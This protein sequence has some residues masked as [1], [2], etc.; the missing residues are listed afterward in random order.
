MG[1]AQRQAEKRRLVTMVHVLLL[2]LQAPTFWTFHLPP[3]C[4]FTG[5]VMPSGFTHCFPWPG[6]HLSLSCP[7]LGVAG[8]PSNLLPTFSLKLTQAL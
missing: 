8:L 7:R 1:Q 3:G 5:S 2:S 6:L 4:S